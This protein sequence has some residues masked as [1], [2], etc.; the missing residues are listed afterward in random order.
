MRWWWW[1]V[2]AF[3]LIGA[4]LIALDWI[5][6]QESEIIR[7]SLSQP[8]NHQIA[9]K[10]VYLNLNRIMWQRPWSREPNWLSVDLNILRRGP[11]EPALRLNCKWFEL[12]G[13]LAAGGGE[14]ICKLMCRPQKLAFL[15]FCTLHP[16]PPPPPPSPSYL[17]P[18]PPHVLTRFSVLAQYL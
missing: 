4:A 5:F 17:H 7:P 2:K 3:W 18:P 8:A 10:S 13:P 1:K 14:V 15:F 16:H 6:S 11:S 12:P 9:A